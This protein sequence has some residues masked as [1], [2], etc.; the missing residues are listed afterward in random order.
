MLDL[1]A[2]HL[3]LAPHLPLLARAFALGL[4]VV[5]PTIVLAAAADALLPNRSG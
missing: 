4:F 1:L 2:R 3:D 5:I